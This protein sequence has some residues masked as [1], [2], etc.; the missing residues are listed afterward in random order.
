MNNTGLIFISL[1]A[2]ALFLL[3]T[4]NQKKRLEVIEYLK[5][6]NPDLLSIIDKRY[7]LMNSQEKTDIYGAINIIK[8]EGFLP[9]DSK[10]FERVKT[11]VL[12]YGMAI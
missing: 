8:K 9:T 10:L 5:E 1:G 4:F 6:K 3:F 12:K 7:D 2:L 11:I